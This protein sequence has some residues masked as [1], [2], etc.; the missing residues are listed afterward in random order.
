[1][2]SDAPK[3]AEADALEGR[4]S[5]QPA[6]LQNSVQQGRCSIKLKS[7]MSGHQGGGQL[8][9]GRGRKIGEESV[10]AAKEVVT[11]KLLDRLFK[12]SQVPVARI[13]VESVVDL[14]EHLAE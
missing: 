6:Q 9:G 3:V 13:V 4:N 14:V 7:S 8:G 10:D 12:H 11:Q 2:R 5:T 1:M